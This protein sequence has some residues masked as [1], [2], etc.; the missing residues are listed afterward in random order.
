MDNE[1]LIKFFENKRKDF[2]ILNEKVKGKKLV[3]VDNSAT[4]QK[5][6]VV[7]DSLVEYYTK[8]NS[9]VHRGAH[10][11]ANISTN[12]Y[13]AVREK[14]SKFINSNK[15]EIVFTRGATESLNMIAFGIEHLIKEGDEIVLTEMEHHANLV[16]WQEIAKRKMVDLNAKD[17]AGAMKIVEGSARSAGIEVK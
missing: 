6:K 9:N 1:Q 11:L 10:T 3:Y 8:Y 17:L 15:E 7:I 5:P 12:K 2:P 16:P 14:V 13:E 4:T